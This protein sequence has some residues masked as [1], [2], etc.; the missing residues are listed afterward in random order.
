MRIDKLHE[1]WTDG[2]QFAI[3]WDNGHL[4]IYRYTRDA[5]GPELVGWL[6][7]ERADNPDWRGVPPSAMGKRWCEL[8]GWPE[9]ATSSAGDWSLV[10]DGDAQLRL[11]GPRAVSRSSI[12]SVQVKGLGH[13]PAELPDD[14]ALFSRSAVLVDAESGVLLLDRQLGLVWSLDANVLVQVAGASVDLQMDGVR[15][16]DGVILHLSTA[17]RLGSLVHIADDGTQTAIAD[18]VG[19][20]CPLHTSK[21][22]VLGLLPR[23]GSWRGLQGALLD[24]GSSGQ[25]FKALDPSS[26]VVV[27]AIPDDLDLQ[28]AASTS[29]C[30]DDLWVVCNGSKALVLV[31]RESGWEKAFELKRPEGNP[32]DLAGRTRLA[33]TKPIF[34]S[35][36]PGP[37]KAKGT[38]RNI[39]ETKVG[40]NFHVRRSQTVQITHIQFGDERATVRDGIANFARTAMRYEHPVPVILEG[41]ASSPGEVLVIVGSLTR[42]K[43]KKPLEIGRLMLE[44]EVEGGLVAVRG[45][46]RLSI[47]PEW[48]SKLGR[49]G[50]LDGSATAPDLTRWL[51]RAMARC[52]V[53]T[54]DEDREGVLSE[55]LRMTERDRIATGE[56][57]PAYKLSSGLHWI[58]IPAEAK[59]IVKVLGAD[60]PFGAFAAKGQ[61]EIQGTDPLGG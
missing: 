27:D 21:G 22:E 58:V 60:H 29:A 11:A 52:R 12:I 53:N 32:L 57:L 31:H 4:C 3:I 39:G 43:T 26:F 16:S 18:T 14:A 34:W 45:D 6:A 46:E 9:G 25:Q 59:R 15:V 42:Y 35:G 50:A 23:E 2:E 61:F 54:A 24:A 49:G 40:A 37:F 10:Q 5:A 1:V 47:L 55:W 28:P 51:H 56:K 36:P 13:V 48:T 44:V 30:T 19:E 17:N 8:T 20:G 41:R 38:L 7:P 33:P